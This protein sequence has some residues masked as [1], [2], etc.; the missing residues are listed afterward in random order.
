MTTFPL[1]FVATLFRGP[2]PINAE[3]FSFSLNH[4]YTVFTLSSR[5]ALGCREQNRPQLYLQAI[6]TS[7]ACPRQRLSSAWAL[8][9]LM[10]SG[11][12]SQI[13]WPHNSPSKSYYL[14]PRTERRVL[15]MSNLCHGLPSLV[16]HQCR[17][18]FVCLG[19]APDCKTFF[20]FTH[21]MLLPFRYTRRAF[22][23]VS[24]RGDANPTAEDCFGN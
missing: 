15:M 10:Q 14:A 23:K 20:W 1:S 18:F 12:G 8:K 24:L 19:H 16:L 17:S 9:A 21:A 22:N 11:L 7:V 2:F 4:S 6:W 3:V 5:S 13:L